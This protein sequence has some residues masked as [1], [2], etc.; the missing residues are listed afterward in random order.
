MQKRLFPLARRAF[1]ALVVATAL[2]ATNGS[3]RADLTPLFDSATAGTGAFAGDTI[4][5]YHVTLSTGSSDLGG[6]GP[7]DFV[8]LYDFAGY[9]PGSAA[10]VSSINTWTKS[11]QLLGLTQ[12]NVAPP[13]NPALLNVSFT[14]TTPTLI[15][16]SGQTVLTFT[17]ASTFA[18]VAG[19]FTPY[20]G[21]STNVSNGTVQGNVGFVQG[22]NV[23]EPT[24][25]A[26]MSV[27]GLM[28]LAPY[29]R[30]KTRRTA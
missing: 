25:I 7:N 2:A 16:G 26:L 29:L 10:V 30:R 5:Q 15:V 1:G 14:Y 13:D 27:G 4:F 24:T 22:P 21:S 11:E 9:V 8:T 17:V 23:P 28:L 6:S 18:N 20:S 3:A 12:A 19:V